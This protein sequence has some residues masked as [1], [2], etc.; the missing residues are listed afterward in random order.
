MLYQFIQNFLATKMECTNESLQTEAYLCIVSD[1]NLALGLQYL[2]EH[3]IH[4]HCILAHSHI[5]TSNTNEFVCYF[6]GKE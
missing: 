2:M 1:K 6:P 3:I 5:I 4:N